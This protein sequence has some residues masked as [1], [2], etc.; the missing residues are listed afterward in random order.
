MFSPPPNITV[1]IYY[2]L[3]N[4]FQ[5]DTH[6]EA[7]NSRILSRKAAAC[8]HAFESVTK[9]QKCKIMY[10][11]DMSSQKKQTGAKSIFHE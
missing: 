3:E 4:P 10:R 5:T 1:S 9:T 8:P 2:Q 6:L 7:Q 11:S